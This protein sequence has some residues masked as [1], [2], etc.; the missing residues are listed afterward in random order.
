M[1]ILFSV[2]FVVILYSCSHQY[3]SLHNNYA[4]FKEDANYC[5]NKVCKTETAKK[6]YIF[7]LISSLQAYGG[8]GGGSI[9][10][11]KNIFPYKRFNS[12]MN[13][14]GY[15]KSNDGIFQLPSLSC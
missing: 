7:S 9:N 1:R 13:E 6:F 3:D 2:I 10:S 4:K 12:C 15:Y 11:Q 14:K 8:G 5:L